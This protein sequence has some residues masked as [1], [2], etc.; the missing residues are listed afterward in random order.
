[1]RSRGWLSL[2]WLRPLVCSGPM[3]VL[4][5]EATQWPSFIDF[6]GCQV[7][8][9][10]ISDAGRQSG[11]PYRPPLA[12]NAR[13]PELSKV[14]DPFAADCWMLGESASSSSRTPVVLRMTPLH[15]QVTCY[16]RCAHFPRRISWH[17]FA[18]CRVGLIAIQTSREP[19]AEA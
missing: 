3:N 2:V 10:G 13:L 16:C 19:R 17:Y 14:F 18:S 6:E 1:M 4:Y 15:C 12:V 5:D 9:K 7:S 11:L 8:R